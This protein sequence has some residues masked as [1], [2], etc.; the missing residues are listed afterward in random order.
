M[1]K[2][3]RQNVILNIINS[4]NITSQSELTAELKKHGVNSTQST[5]SRDLKE[6]NVIKVSTLNG[7]K[8]SV[9]EHVKFNISVREKSI[10]S[11][12]ILSIDQIDGKIVIKT[13]DD[14][15]YFCGKT[16]AA[17]NF[18]NYLYFVNTSDS[19][20]LFAK[21]SNKVNELFLEVKNYL[22]IP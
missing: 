5:V 22:D 20:I 11:Q 3:K 21:D 2:I 14:I 13:L 16:L 10:L 18:I 1:D 7:F 8:Y 19:L 15:S 12:S 9:N 4:K 6:L 17:C